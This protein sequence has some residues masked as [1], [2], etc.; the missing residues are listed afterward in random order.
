MF[1]RINIHIIA[2][3]TQF[4]SM[5]YDGLEW[6]CDLWSEDTCSFPQHLF[7]P[8]TEWTILEKSL[9]TF[10]MEEKTPT[11]STSQGF[12][13]VQIRHGHANAL[14]TVKLYANVYSC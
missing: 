5:K 4:S 3:K 9:N 8:Y 10:E 7:Q 2:D 1:W 11:L 13:E 6:T 14:Q 12:R